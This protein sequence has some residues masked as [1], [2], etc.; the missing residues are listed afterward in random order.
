MPSVDLLHALVPED[1]L[2]DLR[3]TLRRRLTEDELRVQRASPGT[4][5]VRDERLRDD[6]TA[7]RH[8]GLLAA[9]VGAVVG[10]AVAFATGADGGS[11]YLLFAGGGAALAGL[12]GAV[13][14]MQR[15]EVLDDDPATTRTVAADDGLLLLEIRSERFGIWAHRV[16]LARPRVTVLDTAELVAA[17]SRPPLRA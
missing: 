11:Q 2:V 1:E 14:G 10:L 9:L 7:A 15:H 13:V 5:A 16:L 12:I 4:Y 6:L 8:G 17:D 3:R